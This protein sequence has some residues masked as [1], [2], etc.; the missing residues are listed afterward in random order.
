MGIV[1]STYIIDPLGKIAAAWNNV[2]V[3]VKRKKDGEMIE[4]LHV[5]EVKAKLQEL[6]A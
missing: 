1:R 3:R 2:K 6:R 5:E 4:A